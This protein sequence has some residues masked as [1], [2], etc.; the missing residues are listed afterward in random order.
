MNAVDATFLRVATPDDA[1]GI[2]MVRIDS[3]RKAYRGIMPDEYLDSM[4]V[5]DSMHLW[6]RVLSA[7]SAKTSVFVAEL[8]GD[9]VGFAAGK[10]LDEQKF[11]LDA[12]LAA[13]YLIPDLQ[14]QGIGSRLV[15][16]VAQAQQAQ[17]ARGLITWVISQNKIARQFFEKRQAELLVEQAYNWDGIDLLEAGYGWR[18][19]SLF[20]PH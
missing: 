11:G 17:G 13:I 8:D 2:A 1:E 19:L 14:R 10:M 7:A 3:W 9:V 15:T 16:M 5:E 20:S 18:D 12:E 6:Y 4:E